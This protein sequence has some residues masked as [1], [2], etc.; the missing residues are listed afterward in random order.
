MIRVNTHTIE[1]CAI[2]LFL[3]GI[4]PY[5]HAQTIQ[6]IELEVV[7]NVDWDG[8]PSD[9]AIELGADSP[10]DVWTIRIKLF[11]ISMVEDNNCGENFCPATIKASERDNSSISMMVQSTSELNADNPAIHYDALRS[12]DEFNF[13][14]N[15]NFD[16]EEAFEFKD[17]LNGSYVPPN[18][19]RLGTWVHQR[20]FSSATMDAGTIS[21]SSQGFVNF[22]SNPG[23]TFTVEEFFLNNIQQKAFMKRGTATISSVLVI[24][25]SNNPAPALCRYEVVAEWATGYTSFVYIKNLSENPINGWQLNLEFEDYIYLNNFW[26]ASITGIIP[27]F[28]AHNVEWNR[29][30]LSGQE[31]SFGF[32]GSKAPSQ[33]AAATIESVICR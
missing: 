2:F 7:L 5:S 30:I 1:L 11:D 13:S 20:S 23:N 8:S 3:L 22:M 12:F 15:V 6:P 10:S 4:F 14:S 26:A 16:G 18:G 31:I 28:V 33:S 32:T 29:T 19:T 21:R 25:E 24:N 27:N 9:S 17:V